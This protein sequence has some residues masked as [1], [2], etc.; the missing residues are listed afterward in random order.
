MTP[1]LANQAPG[2]AHYWAQSDAITHAVAY[3]LLLMSIASWYYILSKAWSAWRMRKSAIA[4][5][6]CQS[7]GRHQPAQERRH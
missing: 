7:G 2:L 3:V 1:T 4:L 5:E 6:G